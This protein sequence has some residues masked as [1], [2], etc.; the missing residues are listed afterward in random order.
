MLSD[1]P[2]DKLL[3]KTLSKLYKKVLGAP[4]LGKLDREF[5][6]NIIS[7]NIIDLLN[8]ER[9][10]MIARYGA[11]E[12]STIING[13]G[14]KHG[15]PNLW[16]YIKGQELDWWWKKPVL[17]QIEQWSGFFPASVEN[18]ERFCEM[19][20]ADSKQVDLLASWLNSEIYLKE[21]LKNASFF[22]GLFLD[23]FWSEV[24][25]TKALTGKKVLVIHPFESD[26]V[27]QYQKRQ[28]LFIDK[29]VLPQFELITIKAVQSLG[30]IS[31]FTTW[32][33]ALDYMKNQIDKV[34]FD[35]CL[36]GAGA[37]GFPIAAHVKRSG[38]K[39][40]HVGGSLQLLFGIKGKRWESPSY[41]SNELG[42][43]GNYSR[44]MNEHWVY[45]SD[46]NK[47][48]NANN[49]EGACYW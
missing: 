41:G 36:I 25:W 5:D 23:P 43:K 49:V 48:I 35:I 15:R 6:R 20:I 17:N 3:F 12:L 24:P 18:V 45:P 22:Q 26:I 27:T 10:A 32:F 47:P 4:P 37:Y 1:Y 7:Q 11:T 2:I 33:D 29:N 19:M 40:V 39:A 38:K 28:L 13:I 30:G 14:V 9:P 42:S 46:E 31:D 34:D 44:L 16:R 21:E 8:S